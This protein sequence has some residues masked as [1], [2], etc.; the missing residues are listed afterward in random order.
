MP[1]PHI[2][3]FTTDFGLED[4]FVAQMKGAALAVCGD[5]Q[6]VDI[7]HQVPVH[8]VLAGAVHLKMAYAAF[9]AGTVH[10][11][12]VDPGVGTARRAI[13]VRTRSYFFVAP[14]NGLLSLVLEDEPAGDVHALEASHLRRTPVSATFE[15]RDVFAPAAAHIARGIG[16]EHFGPVVDDLARVELPRFSSADG[17]PVSVRVLLVDHFGNVTLRV[18]RSAVDTGDPSRVPRIRVETPGG[19]VDRLLTTYGDA[20]PGKPFLLFN[21]AGFLEIALRE[22]RASDR[23]ELGAGDVVSVIVD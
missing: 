17:H 6:L 15:G 2:V 22:D 7:T 19:T 12:V 13:A 23:L 10:V 3:T 18:P 14:D 20:E 16:L 21:S 5:L 9:P 4:S 11:A 8:D 1:S